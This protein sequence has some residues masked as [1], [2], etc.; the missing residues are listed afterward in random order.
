MRHLLLLF[1]AIVSI[2]A[3][4]QIPA[5]Y[6]GIDFTKIEDA[7]KN[8]LAVLITTTD[9]TS[10]EYTSSFAT[11]T[12]DA[13]K[14]SDLDTGNSSN[15]LL[16]YG[17]NDTDAITQ[18]DRT[19]HIDSSCHTSGCNGLWNREHVYPQS[20]SIPSMTTQFP[21]TGTDVHNL[22]ACDGQANTAR[23]NDIFAAD[24]G[25]AKSLGNSRFYPGDEWIGDVARIIMYMYVRYK[26][27]CPA[28][29]V[30]YGTT[31]DSPFGDMPSVFL[32]WNVTDPP[33][34]YEK[35]R[36]NIFQSIQGNRNPFIDN[37]YLATLI[38]RGPD[39]LNT[40]GLVPTASSNITEEQL[41]MYPTV[42]SGKVY[43]KN[44]TAKDL[45]YIVYNSIGTLIEKGIA[46]KSI[47][48]SNQTKG[49]YFI[50]LGD[51]KAHKVIL[52]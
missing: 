44:S 16:V 13:L 11:D 43:F 50:R 30:G 20:L 23:S 22:R 1:C 6:S 3:S 18:N 35:N 12:W 10:I 7:L 15:V 34:Q 19:R 27:E 4:A 46:K 31:A 41:I 14:Q 42:T 24:T 47:D 45:S 8:E 33:S 29:T 39:A 38:W 25:P 48:L 52:R 21:G 5:Y 28:V 51:S 37:P 49:M 17:Y 36:N 40:W 26:S 2:N 32:Y 9:T